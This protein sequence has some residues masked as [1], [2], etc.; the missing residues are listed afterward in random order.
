MQQ[1]PDGL[2]RFAYVDAVR[3]W[4]ILAVILVHVST[5]W[6][7][8]DG[9]ERWLLESGARGV[10][11]F[12]TASAFTLMHA[13]HSRQDGAR[14]FYLRRLF[15]IAPIFWLAM[16][17]YSIFMPSGST[18]LQTVAAALFVNGAHPSL[19]FAGPVPGGWS[20]A[21]EMAFYL[22]FPLFAA[23]VTTWRRAL[24]LLVVT[25]AF[26][27]AIYPWTSEAWGEGYAIDWLINQ[28][29]AFAAGMAAYFA[30]RDFRR[31]PHRPWLW[32][33]MLVVIV[34]ILWAPN[35]AW[36]R[37][38]APLYA[39]AFGLFIYLLANAKFVLFNN[40]LTRAIGVRSYSIYLIHFAV[41]AAAFPRLAPLMDS[42]SMMGVVF[43]GIACASF[44]IASLTLR[45][46]RWGVAVGS[47]FI[48]RLSPRKREELALAPTTHQSQPL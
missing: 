22:V 27:I 6:P 32:V 17:F 40:A 29:P 37:F 13:W 5:R 47:A 1:P 35:K 36:P 8:F 41:I 39:P 24:I 19:I 21:T 18:P 38:Q 12:F 46:E 23:F 9:Y 10:Q 42:R 14:N 34:Y 11:L 15:R 43:V 3:G 44:A 7:G 25:S 48:R 31:R 33:L 26:G 28:L 20:I 30:V 45:F 4:A 2:A 16:V